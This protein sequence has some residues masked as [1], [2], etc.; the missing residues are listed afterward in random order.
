MANDEKVRSIFPDEEPEDVAENDQVVSAD[1]DAWVWQEATQSKISIAPGLFVTSPHLDS[2]LLG[3]YNESVFTS[4]FA[5][6]EV[7]EEHG[8]HEKTRELI[9]EKLED[10]AKKQDVIEAKAEIIKAL[11][12]EIANLRERLNGAMADL[13]RSKELEACASRLC[14]EVKT[15]SEETR[16]CMSA[17]LADLR[18]YL[19]KFAP[20]RRFFKV[21]FGFLAFF[22]VAMLINIIFKVKIIEPFWDVIG[23]GLTIAMLIVIYF[24]MKDTEQMSGR[25]G[26]P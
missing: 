23:M 14:A 6:A 2:S 5:G 4:I 21:T 17:E 25:M 26:K 9:A 3:H 11:E 18:T 19:S 10:L 12:N 22:S 7:S 24:G 20:H 15:Q 16:K 8:E 1:V 13:V